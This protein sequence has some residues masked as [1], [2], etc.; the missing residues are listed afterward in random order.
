[1]LRRAAALALL[2]LAAAPAAHAAGP[3]IMPLSEVRAG[4]GLHGAP[5]WSRGR[6]SARSTRTSMTWSRPGRTRRPGASSCTVSGAAVDATGVGPGFSGSPVT[7][8]GAD[9]TPRIAGAISE[10]I[11]AYGGKTVLATP[12]Q[13]ILGEPVDPPR[14]ARTGARAA[15]L[16]R[17]ARPIAEPLSFSGLSPAVGARL[18]ARRG[19]R[20]S[21]ARARA[22]AGPRRR[23]RRRADRPG[24]G[25]RRR[26]SRPATST[27]ARS[28]PSRTSTA[29][30]SGASAT[31]STAPAGASLFLTS[32]YVYGVVDNPLATAG[33]R[34]L[35]ARRADGDDRHADAGRRQRGRRPARRARR[36]ASRCSR[37]PRP[38]HAAG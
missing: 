11:G 23:R 6:R 38:R 18:P 24:L 22:A 33:R 7:C 12:I 3:P 14:A 26:R 28:A 4:N 27:P 36:R 10:T 2:A 32:A 17:G 5:P 9:G 8:P 21:H 29:T 16:L 1:M 20:R 34:D 35:Q 15:A 13:A 31:R 30:P 25:D 37:R 19:A